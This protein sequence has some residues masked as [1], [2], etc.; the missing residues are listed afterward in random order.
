MK[1]F[2]IAALALTLAACDGDHSAAEK[3]SLQ[4]LPVL[5]T[6]APDGTKLWKTYDA[7]DNIYPI[8]FSNGG[9]QKSV[10]SGK[11]T[12]VIRVPASQIKSM[13]VCRSPEDCYEAT[14]EN[15]GNTSL[16]VVEK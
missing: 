8:Y 2:A 6:T 15:T 14:P 10:P 11:T 13:T 5:I 4:T 16:D 9:T 1:I 3:Q 12:R 7:S